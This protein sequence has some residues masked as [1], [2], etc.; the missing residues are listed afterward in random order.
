V[1][2]GLVGAVPRFGGPTKAAGPPSVPQGGPQAAACAQEA[3]ARGLRG[4][5]GRAAARARDGG[6]RRGSHFGPQVGAGKQGALVNPPGLCARSL[7]I[8]PVPAVQP[9]AHAREYL[10]PHPTRAAVIPPPFPSFSSDI[11]WWRARVSVWSRAR[12]PRSTA[13]PTWAPPPPSSPSWLP[14]R[15]RLQVAQVRCGGSPPASRGSAACAA[16]SPAPA[17]ASVSPGRAVRVEVCSCRQGG[18]QGP[19]GAAAGRRSGRRRQER[20]AAQAVTRVTGACRCLPLKKAGRGCCVRVGLLCGVVAASERSAAFHACELQ[21][22]GLEAL[23]KACSMSNGTRPASTLT[24]LG[25]SHQL[26]QAQTCKADT[27]D[28]GAPGLSL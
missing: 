2:A 6:R 11:R 20:G 15:P 7:L 28:F 14:S 21:P 5:Q 25:A 23:W 10:R 22:W 9:T 1:R 4:G 18:G 12:A 24:R 8:T 19:A 26:Q 3:R 27:P 16:A 13:A 17:L